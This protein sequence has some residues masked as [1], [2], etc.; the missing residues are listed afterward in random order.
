VQAQLLTVRLGTG[1]RRDSG[2]GRGTQHGRGQHERVL[3]CENE[4]PRKAAAGDAE[5]N[6][7]DPSQT[8]GKRPE[9]DG[10]R[11]REVRRAADMPAL[12]PEVGLA[13]NCEGSRAATHWSMWTGSRRGA[14]LQETAGRRRSMPGNRIP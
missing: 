6:A 4:Q 11:A 10:A 12:E 3:D 14:S 1:R 2:H 13:R 8:D 9:G 7:L 5:E